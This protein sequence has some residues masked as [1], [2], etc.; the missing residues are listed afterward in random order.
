MQEEIWFVR[1]LF[2]FVRQFFVDD[3]QSKKIKYKRYYEMRKRNEN[4][5]QI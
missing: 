4:L 5:D 2:I 3:N 1:Y